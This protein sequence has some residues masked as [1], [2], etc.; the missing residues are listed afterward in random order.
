MFQRHL[1][2]IRQRTLEGNSRKV[3]LT[4]RKICIKTRIQPHTTYASTLL[5]HQQYVNNIVLT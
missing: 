1:R 5:I 2:D 3:I 4:I